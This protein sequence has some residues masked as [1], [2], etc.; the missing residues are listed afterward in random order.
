V[1]SVAI[2]AFYYI[3]DRRHLLRPISIRYVRIGRDTIPIRES[4]VLY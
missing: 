4:S 2:H 3:K 1:A